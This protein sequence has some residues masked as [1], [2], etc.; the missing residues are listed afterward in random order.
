MCVLQAEVAQQQGLL[1]QLKRAGRLTGLFAQELRLAAS[2]SAFGV[3]AVRVRRCV[4]IESTVQWW[5]Y[6]IVTSAP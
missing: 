5:K 6:P 4:N 1:E 2:L 3:R